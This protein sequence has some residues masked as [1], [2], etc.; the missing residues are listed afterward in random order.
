MYIQNFPSQI[1][2]CA[3]SK[4]IWG[5]QPASLAKGSAPRP[6]VTTDV[7]ED[8]VK[9]LDNFLKE[10]PG[11][12]EEL[13]TFPL[14]TRQMFCFFFVPVFLQSWY[15]YI[16]ILYI[17]IY[18]FITFESFSL[19]YRCFGLDGG[20]VFLGHVCENMNIP[21]HIYQ[22]LPMTWL[23]SHYKWTEAFR[24][25]SLVPYPMLSACWLAKA[26]GLSF[27]HFLFFCNFSPFECSSWCVWL[28][29]FTGIQPLLQVGTRSISAE[30]RTGSY[31]ALAGSEQSWPTTTVSITRRSLQR[32]FLGAN[33]YI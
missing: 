16:Y 19:S 3:K 30:A 20:H 22:S 8:V 33:N 24:N 21:I 2:P 13:R 18:I 25:N 26:S 10:N 17:Y 14:R 31:V 15:I 5:S 9:K 6:P 7:L 23:T 11:N 28:F 32:W 4:N 27:R 1:D 12:V 29:S